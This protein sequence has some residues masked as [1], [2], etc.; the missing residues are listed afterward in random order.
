M[1]PRT[2]KD[3]LYELARDGNSALTSV[4][5]WCA[6]ICLVTKQ[7]SVTKLHS[8]IYAAITAAREL[9]ET[10]LVCISCHSNGKM[11][12]PPCNSRGMPDVRLSSYYGWQ[13]ST[14]MLG[15]QKELVMQ[16][17]SQGTYCI[18][19]W[20]MLCVMQHRKRPCWR[21]ASQRSYTWYMHRKRKVICY[22][23]FKG[24]LQINEGCEASLR[25]HDSYC[26][27]VHINSMFSPKLT[28]LRR[29][30]VKD[31]LH[32][33]IINSLVLVMEVRFKRSTTITR[34]CPDA[35]LREPG[36][37][38]GGDMVVLYFHTYDTRGSGKTKE[39]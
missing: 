15:T 26:C 2:Q 5:T 7:S 14:H 30:E 31:V 24:Q 12:A 4:P 27:L 35:N 16:L 11:I 22:W 18:P 23:I 36:Q 21:E 6:L 29:V 19:L 9:Y 3:I 32:P 28:L 1:P 20:V 38:S 13:P 34:S 37:M 39:Y 8:R 33:S 10:R 17:R 25:R